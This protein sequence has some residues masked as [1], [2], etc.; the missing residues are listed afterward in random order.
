M[1]SSG[2]EMVV[3]SVPAEVTVILLDIEGT[4]TPIAF[5]KVRGGRE[6]GSYLCFQTMKYF[7][8]LQTSPWRPEAWERRCGFAPAL[9][10]EDV[11][12][13]GLQGCCASPPCLNLPGS[14]PSAR[15]RWLG[16]DGD[17]GEEGTEE[18]SVAPPQVCAQSPDRCAPALCRVEPGEVVAAV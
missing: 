9:G 16:R 10:W 11:V 14:L 3:L 4:T 12:C 6:R 8:V 13:G 18:G 15:C 2:R 7:K 5:V 1:V 17:G